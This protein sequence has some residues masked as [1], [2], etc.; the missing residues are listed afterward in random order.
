MHYI[1]QQI[2]LAILTYLLCCQR[3]FA[4]INQQFYSIK[5]QTPNGEWLSLEQFKNQVIDT[6]IHIDRYYVVD[7]SCN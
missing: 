1:Q 3:V 2:I 7:K 5:V 4:G 6:E